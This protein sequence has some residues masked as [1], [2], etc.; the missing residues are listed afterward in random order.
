MYEIPL[1]CRVLFDHEMKKMLKLKYKIVDAG[2]VQPTILQL[3]DS[4]CS[5]Q[6]VDLGTLDS[7]YGKK[8]E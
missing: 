8:R 7:I 1:F 3:D 4:S 2:L 6:F 5:D